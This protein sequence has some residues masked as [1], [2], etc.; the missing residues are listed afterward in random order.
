MKA[1]I[2]ALVLSS[3]ALFGWIFPYLINHKSNEL[4]ILGGLLVVV[5]LYFLWVQLTK[6]LKKIDKNK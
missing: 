4:P 6:A 3:L 5:W 2:F 1:K